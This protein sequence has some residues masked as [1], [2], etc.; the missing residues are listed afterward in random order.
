[1]NRH[2]RR[3][4]AARNRAT[5]IRHAAVED[6]LAYMKATNDPTITGATLLLPDGQ[7]LHVPAET[8][9]AMAPDSTAAGRA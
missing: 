3:A 5:K 6:V 2:Q 4:E 7:M 9:Q 1:M 8:A